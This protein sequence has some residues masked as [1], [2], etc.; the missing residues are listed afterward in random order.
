MESYSE[1]KARAS[2]AVDNAAR[3]VARA[4]RSLSDADLVRLKAL[5]RLWAR[6]LP[7]GFGWVDLLNEA[8]ARALDG[9]RRWPPGVR[10]LPF[11]SGVMRSVCDDHWRR[12]QRERD[13]FVR[14]GEVSEHGRWGGERESPP[15]PERVLAA[16]QALVVVHG[17]FAHD[18][19][20]LKIISGLA[21]GLSAKEICALHAI[22]ERAYD[23]ARK[24]MRRAL[25]RR[26]LEWDAS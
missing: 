13:L 24:R 18:P 22:D 9:S 21:E 5:A 1:R 4:I 17:M 20:A 3:D 7:D 26:G 12:L 2:A 19:V 14:V 8:I 10:L 15:S 23:T 6:G 16:A 11:L 25:L